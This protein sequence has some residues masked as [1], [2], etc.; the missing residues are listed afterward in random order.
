M[1][2]IAGLAGGTFPLVIAMF[3]LR[4]RTTMGSAAIAGF[5]MGI[6]YLAGTLG[7]LLDDGALSLCRYCASHGHWWIDD[8]PAGSLP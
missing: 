8:G 1:T 4:T 5:A 2:L 7:S 6:G 3:N